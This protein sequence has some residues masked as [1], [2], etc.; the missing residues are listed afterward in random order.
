[1][2]AELDEEYNVK[3]FEVEDCE[4]LGWTY[5]ETP[6]DESLIGP[7]GIEY[8]ISEEETYEEALFFYLNENDDYDY[9]YSYSDYDYSYDYSYSSSYDYG[10]SY[11]YSDYPYDYSY[12]YSY[13][14]YP[15]DYGYD[16]SYSDSYYYDYSYSDYPYDYSYG[17]SDYSYDYSYDYS[18]SEPVYNQGI[19]LVAEG[20]EL[21]DVYFTFPYYYMFA[22][23]LEEDQIEF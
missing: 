5:A 15:Y 22:E 16:Y 17:Y 2:I 11:S 14:D 4:Y 3:G 12:D 13:S 23:I 20:N 6:T 19:Y 10:Y 7:D 8:M 21:S 1:L 18:D 9:D